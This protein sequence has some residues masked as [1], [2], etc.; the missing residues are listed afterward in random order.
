MIL[1][2]STGRNDE[3]H[4][5]LAGDIGATKSNL[6]ICDWNGLGLS[7]K[8]SA[9]FKTKNFPDINSM[10]RGFLSIEELPGTICFGVAGPVQH[11][12][13]TITNIGWQIDASSISKQF[14]NI[15]VTLIN[16][17]EATAYGLAVI[18][19]KDI[20]VLHE[21]IKYPDGNVA[22]IAPG[23]GLGEAG[24]YFDK[25]GYH[26]FSTEGGHCD[27]A[28]KTETDIE[29]FRYVNKKFGHVSWERL[30]SGPGICNIYDFLYY[31]KSMDEPAWLKEKMLVHDKAG[32]IT[33]Y[34]GE[35][36]ICKET[37][38]MFVRYL[39]EE[40]ANLVLKLKATAGLYIAGGIVPKIIP[41][42]HE[43]LFEKWFTEVGRMK[44]LLKE[45]PVTIIVNDKTPLLGAGYFG[46]HSMNLIW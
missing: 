14:N 32:V 7:V 33:E 17:L 15:P 18:E 44:Y 40:S 6:A 25:D 19:N 23:T 37:V 3:V 41:M 1:N 38:Q 28:Q 26:P 46:A 16:D 2:I 21:G 30:V 29:L 35:C 13:V 42:L 20:H 11:D 45:V 27:F 34:A 43:D 39:A 8:K 12:K 24:L 9:T 4:H 31:E 36:D 10:I 5:I 22:I